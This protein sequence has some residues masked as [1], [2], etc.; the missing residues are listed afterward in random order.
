MNV[1]ADIINKI[2]LYEPNNLYFFLKAVNDVKSKNKDINTMVE[3]GC[4]EAYYSAVFNEMFHN[5]CKNIMV[6]LCIACW[7]KFGKVF[8]ENK[9]NTYFYNNYMGEIIWACWGGQDNPDAMRFKSE[10]K[11]I[12]FNEMLLNSNTDYIDILHMDLQGGEYF[13]LKEIIEN[14][15]IKKINYIFIMTHEFD[16]INYNSY[17]DLLS[18]NNLND[19]ILF[20]DPSYTE[21]GDGLIIIE[22]EKS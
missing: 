22:N 19:K 4:H 6:D 14:N 10:I 16:I 18:N 9:K 13:V 5:K 8:F 3:L 15:L 2:I 21:N 7:E 12:S 1:L 11:K 17:L 20:N